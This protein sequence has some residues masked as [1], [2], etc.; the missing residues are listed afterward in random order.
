MYHLVLLR[1]VRR[2]SEPSF[3]Y[4]LPLPSLSFSAGGVLQPQLKKKRT[5]STPKPKD[6][7]SKRVGRYCLQHQEEDSE[8]DIKTALYKV[9]SHTHT[10]THTHTHSL[11]LSLTP[12]SHSRV[13]YSQHVEGVQVL[14]SQE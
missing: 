14:H 7:Q 4:S 2:Q 9:T 3:H 12:S 10:H 5:V 1:M 11:S 6:F 8:G 13:I